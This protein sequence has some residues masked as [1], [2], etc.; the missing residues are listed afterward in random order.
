MSVWAYVCVCACVCVCLKVGDGGLLQKLEAF[1][2]SEGLRFEQMFIAH[3]VAC[4]C[5][6]V[7]FWSEPKKKKKPPGLFVCL[8]H[9]WSAEAHVHRSTRLHPNEL[10]RPE[11]SQCSMFSVVCKWN[12]GPTSCMFIIRLVPFYVVLM[13]NDLT[14]TAHA[15]NYTP[16]P[17]WLA[18]LLS[19][20]SM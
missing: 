10:Q 13:I 7:A 15:W 2:T 9:G 1:A 12:V 6:S 3:L 19:R 11:A 20:S 18:A 16:Q 8:S 4:H 5:S 17:R 14:S